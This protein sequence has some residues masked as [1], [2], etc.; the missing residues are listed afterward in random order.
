LLREA[1]AD[2]R[3]A[4]QAISPLSKSL[5]LVIEDPEAAAP[6]MLSQGSGAVENLLK[7]A[8]ENKPE[9]SGELRRNL[10]RAILDESGGSAASLKSLL[11]KYRDIVPSLG[12]SG[13]SLKRISDAMETARSSQL[14]VVNPPGTGRVVSIGGHLV[15]AAAAPQAMAWK[16]ATDLGYTYGVPA[17]SR[18][19][20]AIRRAA[21][22]PWLKNL[23]P[24]YGPA[25]GMGVVGMQRAT[26]E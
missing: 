9:V 3:E 1:K 25:I 15:G 23:G 7:W 17:A 16:L 24:G 10:A 21:Y 26:D 13:E 20:Q 2:Y 19:A 11:K 4:S 5:S 12:A 22:M 6:K 8:D 14:G 18:S